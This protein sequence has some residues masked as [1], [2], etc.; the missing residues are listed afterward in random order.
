[1]TLALQDVCDIEEFTEIPVKAYNDHIYK[2]TTRTFD[3]AV[4]RE[5]VKYQRT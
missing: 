4:F 3:P 2:H 5:Y 1:M